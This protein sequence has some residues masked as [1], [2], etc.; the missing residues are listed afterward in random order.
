MKHFFCCAHPILP[1]EYYQQYVCVQWNSKEGKER[2][3]TYITDNTPLAKLGEHNGRIFFHFL[4][5]N[6]VDFMRFRPQN[7]LVVN[8]HYVPL[9]FPPGS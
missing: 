9:H 2:T 5:G 8:T 7:C 3:Q 1:E 6:V 4:N